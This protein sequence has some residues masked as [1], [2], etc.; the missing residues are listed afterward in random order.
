MLILIL[1]PLA[2]LYFY[3]RGNGIA[4]KI[5]NQISSLY[6]KK[7]FLTRETNHTKIAALENSFSSSKN[8]MS[9]Q[10][11]KKVQTQLQNLE[12]KFDVQKKVNALFDSDAVVQADLKQSL[13][14]KNVTELQIA[15]IKT[16]ELPQDQF[17]SHINSAVSSAKEQ[18]SLRVKVSDLFNKV[19]VEPSN[20]NLLQAEETIRTISN[21][22]LK[23]SYQQQLTS[24]CANYYHGKKLIAL[25][26]DDG[27]NPVTTPKL[28]DIL[29]QNKVNAS[30]FEIGN[31]IAGNEALLKR[32]TH[33]GDQISSH[34]W[35]H[36]V[37]TSLSVDEANSE[38]TKAADLIKT[39]SSQDWQLFRPPYEAINQPIL[40]KINFSAVNY[41]VDTLDWK[42]HSV[43]SVYQR[44]IS[45]AH[46][47]AIILMHD[48]HPWSV[49]A[50]PKII[51]TLKNEGYTFV[52]VS[53]MILA[54][55]NLELHKNYFGW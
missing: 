44:A 8:K 7:V 54:K 51:A 28:L 26:Y 49:Q 9:S 41:D 23:T 12:V 2:I 13:L 43:D 25:T 35:T 10:N 55:G 52:T 40:D 47:G 4:T 22:Q 6:Y 33:D 42:I 36:P 18:L 53:Q 32:Q 21:E 45:G 27:P 30:F 46:D 19:S 5:D 29:E 24:I 3:N 15:Q 38:I 17:L 31:Q 50:T 48:I 20:S 11:V 16:S 37:L 1:S 34:T 39:V 14:K